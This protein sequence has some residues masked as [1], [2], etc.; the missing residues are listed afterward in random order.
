MI[1]A[2]VTPADLAA[3]LA[4]GDH[5]DPSHVTAA[6]EEVLSD[7]SRELGPW[8]RSCIKE[9]VLSLRLARRM[10]EQAAAEPACDLPE[11]A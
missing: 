2:A 4:H 6:W 9:A 11:A 8:A 10:L 3:E 1:P 7:P 5:C